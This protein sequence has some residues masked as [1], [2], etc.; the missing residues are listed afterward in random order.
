M[1]TTSFFDIVLTAET[2]DELAEQ[3]SE[4]N[5]IPATV[6][7]EKGR[8]VVVEWAGDSREHEARS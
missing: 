1:V 6:S 3:V 2:I 5:D 4:N 7:A 8:L